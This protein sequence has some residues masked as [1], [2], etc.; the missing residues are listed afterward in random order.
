M[1]ATVPGHDLVDQV[2]GHALDVV[3]HGAGG[4]LTVDDEFVEVLVEHV[5]DDLDQEVR[6]LVHRHRRRALLLA[7]SLLA[8]GDVD[9]AAVQS[10]DVLGDLLLAHPL[11]GGAD[12]GTATVGDDALQD[13]LET[14][15]LS[16]RQLAGDSLGLSARQVH[17]VATGEADPVGQSCALVSQRVLDHLDQHLVALLEGGFDAAGPATDVLGTPV[18]LAGVEHGVAPGADVDERGLHAGQDVLHPAEVDVADGGGLGLAGHEV[19]DEQAVLHDADLGDRA[20]VVGAPGIAHHHGAV[21]VLAAGNELGTGDRPVLLIALGL[22]PATLRLQPG[23][24]LQLHRLVDDADIL[25]LVPVLVLAAERRGL[26]FGV[27]RLLLVGVGSGVDRIILVAASPTPTATAPATAGTIVHRGIGGDDGISPVTAGAASATRV[28]RTVGAVG[29]VGAVRFVVGAL[30]ALG[31][32]LVLL[33]A[34]FLGTGGCTARTDPTDDPAAGDRTLLLDGFDGRLLGLRLRR[35]RFHCVHCVRRFR[36]LRL[37]LPRARGPTTAGPPRPGRRSVLYLVL[38]G[39]GHTGAVELGEERLDIRLRQ[40]RRGA[41]VLDAVVGEHRDQI[42][43]GHPQSLGE[44]VDPDLLPHLPHR[45]V[46]HCG[47]CRGQILHRSIVGGV[48]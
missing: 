25:L 14:L 4:G 3:H 24:A 12:D 5:T 46:L 9:P 26:R 16:L 47:C 37:A 1:G 8:L 34:Q 48:G 6:L 36:R 18:D 30:A 43:A 38:C 17:Q 21:D 7:L 22:T 40:R 32:L 10:V 42:G 28:G 29:A 33:A 2:R 15:T 44:G 19:L 11:G 45:I 27:G 20:G 13:A 31:P 23:R 39:G 41:L 35:F